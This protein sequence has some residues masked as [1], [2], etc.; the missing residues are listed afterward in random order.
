MIEI[1]KLA[2]GYNGRAVFTDVT[3]D[4]VPGEVLVLAGPNGCG[5]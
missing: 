1:R 3:L 2:A 4:F 5:M